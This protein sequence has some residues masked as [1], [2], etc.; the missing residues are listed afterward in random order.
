MDGIK[1]ELE[2][3]QLKV[4][5]NRDGLA[6]DIYALLAKEADF[7]KVCPSSFQTRIS[8]NKNIFYSR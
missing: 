1:E 7:A 4:E 8:K 3:A 6:A 2:E 5:M